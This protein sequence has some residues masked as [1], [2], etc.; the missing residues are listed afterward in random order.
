MMA[1]LN[2]ELHT[3]NGKEERP[4]LQESVTLALQVG[5]VANNIYGQMGLGCASQQDVS[6]RH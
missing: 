5:Q 1:Q 2:T 3:S 6:D 4:R